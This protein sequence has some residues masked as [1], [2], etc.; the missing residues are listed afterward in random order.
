MAMNND[1]SD[2]PDFIHF[3][4]EETRQAGFDHADMVILP[5]CYEHAVSY[6]SGTR[7]APLYLLSASE[8]MEGTDEETLVEWD[9]FSIHTTK[10]IYPPDDPETAVEFMRKKAC[11]ILFPKKFLLCLGGDHAVSI[12]PILAA[13]EIYPN[14]GIL[15]VDA[16]MD[17]R[18]FWNG[19]HFNHACVIRRVHEKLRCPVVSVG[20]R[21]FS[22]KEHEYAKGRNVH[23]FMAHDIPFSDDSWMYQAISL[24]PEHIYLSIDLDGLDPAVIPGTG[25]PEPGGLSYRQLISLI[26]QAAKKRTIV[27]ADICELVKI[28]GTQVSEYTAA[29]I[30]QKILVAIHKKSLAR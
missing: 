16:H 19:S 25:T 10:P 23:H 28:P 26:R 30:A 11:E 8:Q 20:I 27:A 7:E 24:L 4:G 3:G 9:R 22:K 5:L 1:S 18:D 14:I 12:G 13:G 17:L 2:T 6:G 29:R 21:S 15:H